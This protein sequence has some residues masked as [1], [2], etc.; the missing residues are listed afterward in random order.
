MRLRASGVE[1]ASTKQDRLWR[2]R[3]VTAAM[4]AGVLG[5]AAVA[6]SRADDL[7]SFWS[8][9]RMAALS[10]D[11]H[12]IEALTRFPVQAMGVTDDEVRTVGRA[13]FAKTWAAV[14][15]ADTGQVAAPASERSLIEKTLRW[16]GKPADAEQCL[17]TICFARTAAG[18]RLV[19]VYVG[20]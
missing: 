8:Q 14:L 1:I 19:K 15:K 6:P 12:R 20:D 9:F 7:Q 13:G 16:P 18:W 2:V 10:G 4:G 3:L 11:E 5:L 17:A